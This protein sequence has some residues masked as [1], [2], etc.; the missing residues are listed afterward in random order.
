M[1]NLSNRRPS[2]QGPSDRGARQAAEE[3]RRHLER[4]LAGDAPLAESIKSATILLMAAM[5]RLTSKA[6]PA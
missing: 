2:R 1:P 3:A 5:G 6:R 4:G